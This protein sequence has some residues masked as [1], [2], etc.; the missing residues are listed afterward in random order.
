[1]KYILLPVLV[2]ILF[3]LPALA[4]YRGGSHDGYSFLQSKGIQN[5][6]PNLYRGGVDDGNSS[7]ATNG[8]NA[9]PNIYLGGNNDGIAFLQAKGIQNTSPQ[10]YAGGADDGFSSVASAK[11]N[12]LPEIYGGGSDDGFSSLLVTTMNTTPPIYHGGENDGVDMWKGRTPENQL[13]PIYAGGAND[14]DA[15]DGYSFVVSLNQNLSVP[16][17][18]RTEQRAIALIQLTGD[19]FNDDAIL[20]WSTFAAADIGKFELQRSV[21]AGKTFETI[22]SITP[23]TESEKGSDY[24]YSDVRAYHLPAE[25]LLYRLKYTDKSGGFR[26][27]GVVRLSK[28]KTAPVIAAYPNPTSGRFTLVVLNVPDLSGYGYIL[29]NAEGKIL[30]RGAI[31]EAN[32]SFDL[33]GYA[34]ASY[35]LFLQKDG[36][37]IQH[38]TILLTQ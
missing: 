31:S 21:D 29:S 24:R 2:P 10:I 25:F 5:D 37:P 1:M 38:F 9:S 18:T 28:D 12:S 20:G 15:E 16:P 35:H 32:T 22:G 17:P 26:Y 11:V 19:W 4:Q 14:G 27:T 30:K 36:K 34:S 3:S 13:P 8:L 7:F 23:D 6:L 33:S